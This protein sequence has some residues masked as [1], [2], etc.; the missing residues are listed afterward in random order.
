V[1]GVLL[2]LRAPAA[3][4]DAAE[5]MLARVRQLM[6]NARI[7]GFTVQPMVD[8]PDAFELIVGSNE[9]PHCRRNHRRYRA[10]L[11]PLNMHLAHDAIR[12]TRLFSLLQGFRGRPA[13]AIDDIALTL[14]KVSQ[15]TSRK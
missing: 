13:A 15:S 12:R 1:G 3:V 10:A 6:P 14:I 11:P 2:D 8:R 4:R 5:A 9:D 7:E